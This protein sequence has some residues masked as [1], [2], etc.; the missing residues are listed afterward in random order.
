MANYKVCVTSSLNLSL[1][2]PLADVAAGCLATHDQ[3][4]PNFLAI[5]AV[6]ET[7]RTEIGFGPLSKSGPSP[8]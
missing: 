6:M 5:S 8:V 2:L 1:N 7:R 4:R 3:G